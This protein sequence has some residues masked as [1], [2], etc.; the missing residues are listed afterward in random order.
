[1]RIWRKAKIMQGKRSF[2]FAPTFD[3][4]AMMQLADKTVNYDGRELKFVLSK[5]ALVNDVGNKQAQFFFPSPKELTPDCLVLQ[6]AHPV[7]GR[8]AT[9]QEMR[10]VYDHKVV[11]GNKVMLYENST[12]TLSK[13]D[14]IELSDKRAKVALRADAWL[15]SGSESVRDISRECVF[16]GWPV[17]SCVGSYPLRLIKNEVRFMLPFLGTADANICFKYNGQR[18]DNDDLGLGRLVGMSQKGTVTVCVDNH[19][20]PF[21]YD[22]VASAQSDKANRRARRQREKPMVAFIVVTLLMIVGLANHNQP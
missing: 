7:L 5:G 19:E 15:H 1:M 6:V 14:L 20:F 18:I 17:Y 12:Q 13:M 2:S 9:L 8:L 10:A 11:V 16:G 3:S 22:A 21:E 4:R